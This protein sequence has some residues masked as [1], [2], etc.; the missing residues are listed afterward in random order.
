[1]AE[2]DDH[3]CLRC[4]L[5]PIEK[6]QQWVNVGIYLSTWLLEARARG[7]GEAVPW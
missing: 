7:G 4:R 1:V 5:P 2:C 3:G 6:T